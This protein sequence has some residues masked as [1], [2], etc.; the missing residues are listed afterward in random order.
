M[1]KRKLITTT[2]ETMSLLTLLMRPNRRF[3]LSW[4]LLLQAVVEVAG[5]VVVVSKVAAVAAQVTL[6]YPVPRKIL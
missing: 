6:E 5:V 4:L 1:T 2:M 3:S